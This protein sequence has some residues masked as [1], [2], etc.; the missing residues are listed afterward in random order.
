VGPQSGDAEGH[1]AW[2]DAIKAFLKNDLLA[3]SQGCDDFA[4]VVN[5]ARP[6]PE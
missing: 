1:I 2:A 4:I 6:R 3:L 5:A